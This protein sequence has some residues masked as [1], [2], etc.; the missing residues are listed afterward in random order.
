MGKKRQ[1]DALHAANNWQKA[2]LKAAALVHEIDNSEAV[3]EEYKT[4]LDELTL[5]AVQENIVARRK[6]VEDYLMKARDHYVSEINRIGEEYFKDI[7]KV[8][9]DKL[10]K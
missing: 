10:A 6:D 7:D 2:Q 1:K 8:I 5:T 9:K 4:E 3:I